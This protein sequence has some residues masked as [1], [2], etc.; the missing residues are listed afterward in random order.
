MRFRGEN[1][2]YSRVNYTADWT[3]SATYR[4]VASKTMLLLVIAAISAYSVALNFGDSLSF[5][6][7][8]GALIVAPLGAL[9]F[10]VLAHR[11]AQ[12]AWIFSIMYAILE[13][14]FLGVLSLLVAYQ[15]GTDAVLYAMA[16]TFGALF[17]MLILYSTRIINV[18]QGFMSF[19]L[20]ALGA[21][22]FLSLIGLG[23]WLFGG[24]AYFFS[25][26]YMAVVVFSL[27]VSV[28]FLLYD[29]RSIEN[30]VSSNAGKQY[31]W[32]LALGLVTTIVWIYVQILR[33]ILIL[34]RRR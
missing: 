25:P 31:E 23:I 29:F 27:I 26:F 13:G 28:L 22:F 18:G 9:V 24:T 17:V 4:G 2:V 15:V 16:G 21:V 6:S 3:E 5:G 19:M 10:V 14:A 32:S 30:L 33:L 12:M 20:T 11:N 7:L 8:I 34:S 1:P